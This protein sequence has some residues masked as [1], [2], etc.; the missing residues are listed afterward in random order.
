MPTRVTIRL[1]GV[2]L[3]MALAA[4]VAVG[5]IHFPPMTLQKLCKAATH[6]RLLSVKKYDKK[7]GIIVFAVVENLKGQN[8]RIPSFRHAIRTDAD[9]VKPIL[10]WVGDD[11]WAVMFSI[12]ADPRGTPVACGYVFIDDYCYSVDYNRG[13]EY[14]LLIRAEPNLSAC[15]YGSAKQLRTM[16]KDIL[17]G[18]DL[19]V[20][21]KVPSP[22]VSRE[23][24]EKRVK[25]V[26]E[27]LKKH[28]NK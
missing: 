27:I 25:E 8:P 11:K 14:W 5:H 6:I 20:P 9:G 3:V 22:L 24:Q 15:Y 10:D 21:V 1:V 12:E 28:R 7:R 17:D 4:S 19:K 13:G 16:A 23:G 18:K 26:T 2:A